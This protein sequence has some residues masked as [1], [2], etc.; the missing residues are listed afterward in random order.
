M[1]VRPGGLIDLT[2]FDFRIYGHDKKPVPIDANASAIAKW[3]HMAH[4]AVKQQG[5]EPDASN[6]LYNW[7]SSNQ[8]FEDVVYRHWW[9]QVA[10]W[11]RGDDPESR[12][13]N[14]W[15]AAMRDDILVSVHHRSRT[16]HLT[17]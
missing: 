11:N 1:T 10:P 8:Q 12:R 14:R 13:M 16:A 3:M 4:Q 5:G 2:E 6:H 17:M 15:G 7:V 9:F